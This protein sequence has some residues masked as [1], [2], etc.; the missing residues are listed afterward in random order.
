MRKN[1]PPEL[2]RELERDWREELEEKIK[3]GGVFWRWKVLLP[4]FALSSLL[5]LLINKIPDEPVERNILILVVYVVFG[6]GAYILNFLLGIALFLKLATSVFKIALFP[7]KPIFKVFMKK[8]QVQP[9]PVTS[10]SESTEPEKPE[11][12][13]KELSE[14]PVGPLKYYIKGQNKAVAEVVKAIRV[15]ATA[16]MKGNEKRRRVLASMIFVGATGVGKTETAKV[17]ANYMANFGYQFIRVDLNLYRTPESV[18]TLIGSPRGYVGSE[19]GG[20]LTRKLMSNPRAVILFDEME[21]AHPDL[22]PTFMTMLDEG[23]IEEQSTGEKVHLDMAVIIFTSNLESERIADM[24]ERIKDDVQLEL[25][26]R[27]VVETYFGRPEIVGRIDRIVPFKRLSFEDLVEIAE[28]LMR[29][30]EDVLLSE[31]SPYR[32]FSGRA[33][34]IVARAFTRKY[35]DVARKY[36]VRVFLKKIEEDL[37]EGKLPELT[38]G[39]IEVAEV[40]KTTR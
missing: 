7:F 2:R 28:R 16:L 27:K 31:N 33:G 13:L 34:I 39:R 3:S 17:L 40:R 6:I 15:G 8:E 26:L 12:P 32:R 9:V 22:H 21:K 24:V 29:K 25:E 10:E 11:D 14:F 1:I 38:G 35:E 20:E 19:Q 5:V 4:L 36:G 37:I 23:Y 30:Y 18:W